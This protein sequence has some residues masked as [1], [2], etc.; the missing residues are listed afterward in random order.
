MVEIVKAGSEFLV[1]SQVTGF[2]DQPSIT[3]LASGGFVATWVDY[4]AASGLGVAKAQ[5]YS[6]AGAKVG[7]EFAVA[8]GAGTDQSF[9]TVASLASGGFVVTWTE[10][11]VQS[12]YKIKAQVYDAAGAVAAPAFL[13]NSQTW[14]QQGG[15]N[16]PGNHNPTITGLAG[17]GFVVTWQDYAG[18]AGDASGAGVLAQ[19][20]NAAGAAQGSAVRVNTQTTGDQTQPSVT[21]LVGGGFV[22]T[23]MDGN[24]NS[25][26]MKAQ[27][28][29]AAGAKVGG[30]ILVDAEAQSD[31]A[32]PVVTGLAGG[33]FAVAWQDSSPAPGEPDTLIRA[34]IF[35]AAGAKV[36]T[37]LL[38]SDTAA[39]ERDF[40]SI[41]SLPDGGFVVTW[42]HFVSPTDSDIKA[43]IFDVSGS[44]VG[45]EMLINTVTAGYQE[46]PVISGIGGGF[47]IAWGDG[48]GLGGDADGTSIKAQVYT[49]SSY[50][51]MTGTEGVDTLTGTGRDDHIIGLGGNDTLTGLGGNDLLD[52]GAGADTMAGGLGDDIYVVD[53]AGDVVTEQAGQG[54]DTVQTTLASYTLGANV[55]NLTFTDNAAHTGT[56]NALNNVLTGGGG[57]DNLN[58]GA[59][60]DRMV[61]G[62]G[63]D[64]YTVDNA[65]DVVVE[66]GGE[67]TDTVSASIT[68]TLGANVENLTLSGSAAINGIGNAD[69]NVITGNAAANVLAGLGGNDTLN[70]GAGADTMAGGL[71]DDSYVVD[72][73]G[74]VTT[75]AA[76]EGTDLVTASITWTLGANLENLTLSGSTAINGT[77]NGSANV[78]TGNAAA[79]VLTG[80][81]GND[82]LNGGAGNDT[83]VGGLGDDSYVVDSTGD[84]V[85]ELA[86]EGTDLVTSAITWTLG[87]NVE[88]L[89][90]SGSAAINGTGNGDANVITGNA[91]ANTLTGLGGNDTLNGGAGTD[92][93]I[94]G[95]GDDTYVV[96]NIGDVVTEAAGQGTD[97][98]QTALSSYT[99][100]ANV[101]NLIFTNGSN[102]TGV[103][104]ALANVITGNAGNDTLDG[105]A[106]ADT[107]LGGIGNDSYVI[108]NAGDAVNELAGQGTDLVTASV[109]YTLSANVEN[110][111]LSGSGAISGTGNADANVITG[112]SGGN[113]LTGLGGNDTLVGGTGADTLIGGQGND[114]YVVDNSGDVVTELAGEGTDLV[115]TTL[116]TYALTAN[117]ENLT[118]TNASAHTGTGNALANTIIGNAGNDT[119]NGGAGADTL[120][121][122]AG[123]DSYVVDVAGD[124]VTEQAAQGT[125]LVT[126]SLTWTL[127]AN[128]ENLT[129]SGTAAINGTGNGDANVLTGNAA[130]NVLTGLAGNDT[131]NGGAGNDT[132]IGGLGDDIYVVD[133]AGDVVTEA[134]GEGIDT[135]QT[136]LASYTLGANVENL[137]F[138]NSAVHTGIGNALANVITGNSAS[139]TLSGLDGDDTLIGGLGNDTLQGGAGSDR[140]VGGA[141]K[142]ILNGGA[143]ADTFVFDT[144][145]NSASNLD[146]VQDFASGSDVLSFSRAIY[147]GFAAA[148]AMGADAFWSGAG[149]NAAHDVTDRFIY[150][151]TTGVL[152]Y[153]ADGTGSAAA[154]QVAVLTGTPALA[155]SDFL[156]TA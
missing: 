149:V 107:L 76:G 23:W 122:G 59:G 154:V 21:S 146:T 43:Q 131:L 65:G 121:G 108:D 81:G 37:S 139:N 64:T 39:G 104:N 53:N 129:L 17:G 62:A 86:G 141:G 119:L 137:T 51:V 102:H 57:A 25:T 49:V 155:F 32:L 116:A 94:G 28:F 150:N 128:L 54:T 18:T 148:G 33:G 22:V 80:L 42:Q 112:N 66:N 135:V 134:A 106:G 145:P 34:A 124:V 10:A 74:D 153:D 8:A 123:N 60:A 79:N 126:A 92:I 71:G 97:T 105:G 90:L 44:K 110:L 15:N 40:P 69:A 118:F 38:V 36:G 93:L 6:A 68:W 101:E 31:Q 100:A 147:T 45:T 114:T 132:L 46:H 98:V 4:S 96:D 3:G 95:L 1:N 89:T 27:L 67:G 130:V 14:T 117:V 109:S 2:Q 56:G 41:T 127:G 58:G 70:G 7:G 35:S 52:G 136:T 125:D 73:A 75:E 120:I 156:I 115:Q 16:L 5:L 47:V 30:E 138:T 13:V 29:S 20:Y 12:D 83:M 91:A 55:E 103:G 78:I 144:A 63:N 99:L 113:T 11:G 19:V 143:G 24:A 82:T 152:W 61:G 84:V 26:A 88:N 87:A 9:P 48:S 133:A 85:T 140:L 151:T 50:N 72:N 111:T 77:G 142:D